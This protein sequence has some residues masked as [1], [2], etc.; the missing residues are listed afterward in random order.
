MDLI[1]EISDK[2]LQECQLG[3]RPDWQSVQIRVREWK[4]L[5]DRPPR[6]K[7]KSVYVRELNILDGVIGGLEKIE[8]D[9][10]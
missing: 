9:S 6:I 7:K 8:Y 3:K 1:Q 10:N 4:A 2:K 5:G